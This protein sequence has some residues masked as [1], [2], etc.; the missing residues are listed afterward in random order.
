M[1]RALRARDLIVETCGAEVELIPGGSGIFE[2]EIDGR[3][4]YSKRNTGRFPT[5]DEVRDL[6]R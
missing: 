2:I 1:P 6:V 3:T 5:D 4:V